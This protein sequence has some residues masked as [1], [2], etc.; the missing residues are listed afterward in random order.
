MFGVLDRLAQ[1]GDERLRDAGG[2]VRPGD[3]EVQGRW[4]LQRVEPPSELDQ[5]VI[6][7]KDVQRLAGAERDQERRVAND[8]ELGNA[9][10][11]FADLPRRLEDA[12]GYLEVS[13]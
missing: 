11:P 13:D 3:A 4:K 2:G 10:D 6:H 12:V 7:V 9:L 8:L 5:P 1:V